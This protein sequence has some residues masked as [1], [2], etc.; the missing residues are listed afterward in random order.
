MPRILVVD[1]HNTQRAVCKQRLPYVHDH[2]IHGVDPEWVQVAFAALQKHDTIV[3]RNL[4]M[5]GKHPGASSLNLNILSGRGK[6]LIAIT[7]RPNETPAQD[8]HK[9][10]EVRG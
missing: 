3:S 9:A 1:L 7:Q 10:L 4:R 8:Q 2:E 6:T 5:S